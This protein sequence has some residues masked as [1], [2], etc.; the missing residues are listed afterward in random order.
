MAVPVI[1]VLGWPNSTITVNEAA[2]VT[3]HQTADRRPERRNQ[4]WVMGEHCG[5]IGV[6]GDVRVVARIAA[7]WTSGTPRRRCGEIHIATTRAA[8]DRQP[9][10][11]SME[12]PSNATTARSLSAWWYWVRSSCR[13]V[14]EYSPQVHC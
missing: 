6:E 4:S 12:R 3:A 10:A 8:W 1:H 5:S 2:A 13:S 11:P 14:S 9:I 7:T